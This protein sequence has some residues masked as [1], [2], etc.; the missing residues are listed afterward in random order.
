MDERILESIKKSDK[1]LIGIGES[2]QEKYESLR[3]EEFLILEKENPLEAG[4]RKLQFLKEHSNDDVIRAYKSLFELIKD[5]DYYI[6]S[7]CTDDKIFNVDFDKTKIVTPCG[8]FRFLQCK[9]NCMKELLPVSDEMIK[10]KSEIVCP[11]CNS[12]T[13]F[14]QLP[15]ENYNEDGYLPD[16]QK[17]NQWLQNTLNKPICIL[18]LGIGLTY[19]TVIRWPFEKIAFYNQK[20]VLYRVHDS[21][22]QTTKELKEKCISIK[23][24]PIGFLNN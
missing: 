24:D 10:N 4:F 21:L 23:N 9:E 15:T 11:H 8:G 6:I 14:N 12:T 18:E 22:Y 3:T 2:F 19:P 20:A 13:C 16:W 1:I 5:K 17:Y 7:T